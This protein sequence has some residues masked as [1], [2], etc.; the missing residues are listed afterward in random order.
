MASITNDP[1]SQG[2]LKTIEDFNTAC[3]RA[4]IEAMM[5]VTAKDVIFENTWPPPDGARLSGREAFRGFGSTS[6]R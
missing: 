1:V 5:A 6:S 3:N 4:D 2:T